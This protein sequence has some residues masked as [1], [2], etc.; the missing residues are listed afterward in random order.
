MIL[1]D[2]DPR[3]VDAICDLTQSAF[4]PMAYADGNEGPAIAQMRRAGELTISLVAEVSNEVVAH[5]AFSPALIDDTHAGWYALGPVAV[6]PDH[7]GQ[8]IGRAIIEA[9]LARLRDTGA[10][11]CVLIGDP[12]L[13]SRFGFTCEN[14]LTY[15][16]LATRYVQFIAFTAPPPAGEVRF[17]D[18]LE[19]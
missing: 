16:T 10:A 11:G 13:Y 1:R 2:E 3:D 8:G 14:A 15:R 9:G 12:A 6:R 5:I 19:A 18:A 4:A 7:Q 17:V